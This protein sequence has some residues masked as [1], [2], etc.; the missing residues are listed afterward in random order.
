MTIIN[1]RYCLT[2]TGMVIKTCRSY[3]TVQKSGVKNKKKTDIIVLFRMHLT[4]TEK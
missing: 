3:T 2:D 4:I 1:N